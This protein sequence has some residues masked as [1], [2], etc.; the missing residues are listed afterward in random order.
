MSMTIEQLVAI[1]FLCIWIVIFIVHV[2]GEKGFIKGIV[3]G[4][5]QSGLIIIM[6]SIAY[7]AGVY[8]VGGV[9]F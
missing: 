8:A 6:T 3:T 4:F 1:T 9:L 7:V 5:W 2:E